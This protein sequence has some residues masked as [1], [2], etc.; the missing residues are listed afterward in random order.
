MK[1]TAIFI[2]A[3]LPPLIAQAA[4]LKAGKD[5]RNCSTDDQCVMIDG[6]CGKTAV[7]RLAEREAIAFYKQEAAKAKCVESF[8][9]VKEKV[10]RCHLGGCDTRP[11]QASDDAPATQ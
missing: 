2:L 4:E 9:T 6:K 11:R 5:W 10:V 1:R 3:L 7:N 8:W